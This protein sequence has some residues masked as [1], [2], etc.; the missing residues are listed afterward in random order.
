MFKNFVGFE[1]W[2]EK[3][4]E[5]VFWFLVVF[6]SCFSEGCRR[7]ISEFSS[8]LFVLV[9]LGKSFFSKSVLLFDKRVFVFV[10]LVYLILIKNLFF[11]NLFG[12]GCL[13]DVVKSMIDGGII[14]CLISIFY[15]IDFDYFDVLKFVIFIFKFFEILMSVVNIVE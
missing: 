7:I 15:V 13:F 4:F 14:K 10:G 6:C 12:C 1:V 8:V 3:L 5:K 11:S 9:F 2:K